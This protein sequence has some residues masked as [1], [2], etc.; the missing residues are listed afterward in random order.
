MYKDCYVADLFEVF[1]GKSKYTKAYGNDN[2]GQ[3]PVYSA[4]LSGPMTHINHFDYDGE[5]LS[6][7]TNGYAGN[8]QILNG[9]FSINA[10]RGLLKPINDDIHLDY[11]RKVL[12]PKLRKQAIGRIVDGKKNEYTKL[13]PTKVTNTLISIPVDDRGKVSYQAQKAIVQ[14]VLLIESRQRDISNII[15]RINEATVQIVFDGMKK[16]VDFSDER[17]F[18]SEIGKRVLKKDLLEEGVPAYSA[19]V[20]KPLGFIK[21]S[22]L[23][24]FSRPSLLWGIDGIF[25]WAYIPENTKFASTDHCGRLTIKTSGLDAKYVYYALKSTKDQYGF[26]RTYRASLTNMRRVVSINVPVD[27]NG[28]FDLDAQIE[29]AERYEKL[30]K[31]KNNIVD[32]L[33]SVSFAQVNLVE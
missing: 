5:F 6:W 12:Q 4:S 14:R 7:I 32:C 20:N 24:D 15:E 33:K 31:A 2:P 10:D 19:N 23:D 21:G 18:T 22:N 3:Y 27:K 30:E 13:S 28:N 1:R 29:I 9:R 8:V 11:V 26:D 16:S 17:L 25:D